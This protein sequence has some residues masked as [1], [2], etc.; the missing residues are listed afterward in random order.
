MAALLRRALR[1][2]SASSH[3]FTRVARP[4]TV[5][6]IIAA[7]YSD[8]NDERM[9]GDYPNLPPVSAQEKSPFGWW[10]PQ[11]RR[12]SEET[13]HEEDDVLNM[14]MYDTESMSPVNKWQGLGSIL[15]VFGL[16]GV[17]LYA[18]YLYDMP[19]RNPAA[20]KEYPYSNLYLSR[21]GDPSKPPSEEDLKKRV[22]TSY[23]S[24]D[25]MC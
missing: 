24:S 6:R 20:P 12:N 4:V 5:P 17:F 19:S 18:A 7:Q 22:R 11:D 15:A 13:I 10:D 23:I 3:L 16:F 2:S 14:W 25:I 1:V 8:K 21:G 9:I